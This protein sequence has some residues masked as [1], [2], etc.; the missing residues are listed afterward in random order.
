MTLTLAYWSKLS[1]SRYAVKLSEEEEE[2]RK[3]YKVKISFTKWEWLANQK[4]NTKIHEIR[5]GTKW[6]SNETRAMQQ[7][8][9]FKAR[10]SIDSCHGFVRK[11]G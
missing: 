3:L 7:I 10:G 5:G 4:L 8:S 1:R 2:E 6:L 9:I 11:A